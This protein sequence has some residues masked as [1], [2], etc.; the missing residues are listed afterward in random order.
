MNRLSESNGTIP[1]A[2]HQQALPPRTP[3]TP[4]SDRGKPSED[5]RPWEPTP[6]EASEVM[7]SLGPEPTQASYR[8]TDIRETKTQASELVELIGELVCSCSL[9]LAAPRL[10]IERVR[11]LRRRWADLFLKA[12]S[13]FST[14]VGLQS[15]WRTIRQLTQM[16]ESAGR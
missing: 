15:L 8:S 13:A 9:A 12:D 16:A 6:E 4:I 2:H 7:E 11:A 14:R 10:S 3:G 1:R 5:I